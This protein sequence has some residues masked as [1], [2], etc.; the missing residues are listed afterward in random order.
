MI[1]ILYIIQYSLSLG[2]AQYH[3]RVT[4]SSSN[5]LTLDHA[6]LYCVGV[7]L[8][9]H[10][11][12]QSDRV[13]VLASPV[14]DVNMH[15]WNLSRVRRFVIIDA[16]IQMELCSQCVGSYQKRVITFLLPVEY[17][18]KC[19]T[20]LLHEMHAVDTRPQNV[21]GCPTIYDLPHQCS[22]NPNPVSSSTAKT[23]PPPYCTDAELAVLHT[24]EIIE[25]N[26]PHQRHF[27]ISTAST[28]T[29]EFI[30]PLSGAT[31]HQPTTLP[32]R[33]NL[34]PN[35]HQ[36]VKT[37]VSHPQR[38][39]NFE[40]PYHISQRI[41]ISDNGTV[42]RESQVLGSG[43]GEFRR[44]TH[45]SHG[46]NPVYVSSGTPMN[47]GGY[48]VPSKANTRPLYQREFIGR[49]PPLIPP[50]NSSP[51]AKQRSFSEPG[52]LGEENGYQ[53]EENSCSP[54]PLPPPLE[55][56]P[57]P[58]K[59]ESYLCSPP[60]QPSP[61]SSPHSSPVLIHTEV[62][63]VNV[64]EWIPPS[65]SFSGSSSSLCT[66]DVTNAEFALMTKVS[67][68]NNIIPALPPRRG[69]YEPKRPKPI[70][71]RHIRHETQISSSGSP[72]MI[73]EKRPVPVPRQRGTH[74]FIQ[75]THG[76]KPTEKTRLPPKRRNPSPPDWCIEERPRSSSYVCRS[77]SSEGSLKYLPETQ[78]TCIFSNEC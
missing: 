52:L 41:I 13:L 40:T 34:R 68:K 70:P 63:Y 21:D 8:P 62:E 61:S 55:V 49:K 65:T 64:D 18:D 2:S 57:S 1:K 45:S 58:P 32:S 54:P 14:N 37:R 12:G 15:A 33:D 11:S 26:T 76:A 4:G 5:N 73:G 27:T 39:R 44:Q 66:D 24:Q 10:S 75:S 71:R 28:Q 78:R 3:V 23:A 19:M 50:R 25:T 20:F 42:T 30:D 46:L 51:L 74:G 38:G 17:I 69:S 29:H 53:K 43:S 22:V 47:N 77:A 60:S 48:N 67:F 35:Y 72:S 59:V 6:L 16:G 36:V 9:S 7:N 56:S 31:P